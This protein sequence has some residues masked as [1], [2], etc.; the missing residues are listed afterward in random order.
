M[1]VKISKS[2]I[3]YDNAHIFSI[4]KNTCFTKEFQ[5]SKKVHSVF[6]FFY[7]KYT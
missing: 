6:Y 2:F 5:R 1:F 3:D 4:R 7:D